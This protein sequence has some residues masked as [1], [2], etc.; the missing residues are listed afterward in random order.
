MS[1]LKFSKEDQTA[2]KGKKEKPSK[3]K[4]RKHRRMTGQK[5]RALIIKAIL[6]IW[7]LQ[8][9]DRDQMCQWCGARIE[10]ATL[11]AHHIIARSTLRRMGNIAG[12][13]DKD[14]GITLCW[15][16]HFNRIKRQ[17]REYVIMLDKFLA[18]RNL[19][20]AILMER[21]KLKTRFA[22]DDLLLLYEHDL[23]VEL[24]HR[25]SQYQERINKINKR[26]LSKIEK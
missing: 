9:R 15:D 6:D 5:R 3:S 4:K 18:K 12:Y 25:D 23:C 8:I 7:S 10:N 22:T 14:N 2:Y 19:T 1:K 11:Q 20:E 13:F 24:L 16:C 17:P 26:H 21:F